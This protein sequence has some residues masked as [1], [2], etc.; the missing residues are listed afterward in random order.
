ME[1]LATLKINDLEGNL[2]HQA[3]GV[4]SDDMGHTL[5][6]FIDRYGEHIEE[7]L[8]NQIEPDEDDFGK[9]IIRLYYLALSDEFEDDDTDEPDETDSEDDENELVTEYSDGVTM[10]D[11]SLTNERE[12]IHFG[13]IR[14]EYEKVK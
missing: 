1:V 6:E 2:L 5:D 3:R 11:Q 10:Y 12:V 9:I 8:L 7:Y 4:F 13:T 14:Q